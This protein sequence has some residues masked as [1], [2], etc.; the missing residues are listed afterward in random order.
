MAKEPTDKAICAALV[1]WAKAHSKAEEIRR[2]RPFSIAAYESAI[3]G[4]MDAEG[5]VFRLAKRLLAQERK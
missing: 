1:R 4:M 5:S 3:G 2:S